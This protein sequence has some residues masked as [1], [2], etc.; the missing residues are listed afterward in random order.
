MAFQI[1]RMFYYPK[2]WS[3]EIYEKNIYLNNF[4]LMSPSGIVIINILKKKVTRYIITSIATC[5]IG[6]TVINVL[7]IMS[8]STFKTDV[9][10][11]VKTKQSY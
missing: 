2:I 4:S 10:L 3:L 11:Y 9:I 8:V 5:P 1:L 7:V 6:L